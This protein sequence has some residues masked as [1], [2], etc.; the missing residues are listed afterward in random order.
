MRPGLVQQ[1]WGVTTMTVYD[2]FSN[3]IIF[4]EDGEI[5]SKVSG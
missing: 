4:S 2:P 1:P 3:H 5:T